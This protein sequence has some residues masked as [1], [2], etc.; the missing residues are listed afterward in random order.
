MTMTC[1]DHLADNNDS[2]S[3]EKQLGSSY[4]EVEYFHAR[5]PND[6]QSTLLFPGLSSA[7][8]KSL[9]SGKVGLAEKSKKRTASSLSPP[10]LLHLWDP[11]DE[12]FL[13]V[14]FQRT[15]A[16]YGQVVAIHHN[17]HNSAE[18]ADRGLLVNV[19]IASQSSWRLTFHLLPS[20]VMQDN[21]SYAETDTL[22]TPPYRVDEHLVQLESNGKFRHGYQITSVLSSTAMKMDRTEQETKELANK[23]AQLLHTHHVNILRNTRIGDY[24]WLWESLPSSSSAPSRRQYEEV[25]VKCVQRDAHTAQLVFARYPAHRMHLMQQTVTQRTIDHYLVSYADADVNNAEDIKAMGRGEERG[26]LRVRG[27]ITAT[28]E[29]TFPVPHAHPV[30]H[31]V[32]HHTLHW[33]SLVPLTAQPAHFLLRH[34]R[35]KE[36]KLSATLSSCFLYHAA[37]SLPAPLVYAAEILC[38][39]LGKDYL[40]K[41]FGGC[42]AIAAFVVFN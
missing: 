35:Y 36:K 37:V 30:T 14:T 6:V 19:E 13:P 41:C 22:H 34:L 11:V 5:S 27:T 32:A 15:I 4:Y 10:Q 26:V 21:A 1:L 28:Q 2:Q 25:L 24:L 20:I 42:W 18:I 17:Q 8:L 33:H 29:L 38:V 12:K 23:E 7:F 9:P 3:D 16:T 40:F 39:L 31:N